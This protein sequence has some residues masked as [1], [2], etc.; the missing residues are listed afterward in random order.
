MTLSRSPSPVPGGGW[1]SPGLSLDSGRSTPAN[2]SGGPVV[3][4]SAKMRPHNSSTFSSFSTQNKADI[5]GDYRAVSRSLTGSVRLG[6]KNMDG[7]QDG[8][9]R[10]HSLVEFD[11]FMG[12][13]AED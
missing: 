10:Y 8:F 9:E 6:R 4:E 13:W 3:W 1:S 7:D 11:R 2:V 12:E 5:C